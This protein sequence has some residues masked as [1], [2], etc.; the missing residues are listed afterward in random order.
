MN[1][2]SDQV[3]NDDHDCSNI[4]LSMDDHKYNGTHYNGKDSCNDNDDNGE[5]KY[6]VQK[7]TYED[8]EREDEYR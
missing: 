1:S 6:G 7:Y 3:L 5:S 4:A 8:T 2:I